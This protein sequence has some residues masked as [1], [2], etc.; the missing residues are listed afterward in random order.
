MA[1]PPARF[2]T[3]SSSCCSWALDCAAVER[4]NTETSSV[5]SHGLRL[6]RLAVR[7]ELSLCTIFLTEPR[8]RPPLLSPASNPGPAGREIVRRGPRQRF[9]VCSRYLP[10]DLR[11]AGPGQQICLFRSYRNPS[12]GPETLLR[13]PS[14]NEAPPSA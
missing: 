3:I 2:A 6:R 8:E 5:H 4:I 7:I 9:C 13:R 10:L 11:P 14:R 12:C 1:R